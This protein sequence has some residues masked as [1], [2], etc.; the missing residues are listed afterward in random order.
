MH[1]YNRK[2]DRISGDI[3]EEASPN[4]VLNAYPPHPN[5]RVALKRP[6]QYEKRS[7]ALVSFPINQK[8]AH[9]A[10]RIS[11]GSTTYLLLTDRRARA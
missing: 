2:I 4:A 6:N 5:G 8:L 11:L 3:E 9:L 7:I 10:L 1:E